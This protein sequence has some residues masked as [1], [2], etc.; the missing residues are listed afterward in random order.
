MAIDGFVVE[1]ASEEW[2]Q[3]VLRPRKVLVEYVGS[4]IFAP[5]LLGF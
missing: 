2:G 3:E 4:S 1:A 5:D